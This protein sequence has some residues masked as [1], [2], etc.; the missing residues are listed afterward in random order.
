[1]QAKELLGQNKISYVEKD[2]NADAQAR[3]ELIAR[4]I[5][6]V[7]AF[8]IGEDMVVGLDQERILRLVDHR[9]IA[10]PNCRVKL[11]LPLDRGPGRATCPQCKNSFDWQP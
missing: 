10:C 9:T 11:R 1:M 4:N 3:Q 7:P 8:L 5:S 6:G 2:I